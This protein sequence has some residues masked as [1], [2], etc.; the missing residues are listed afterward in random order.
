[1]AAIYGRHLID[2][3][4]ERMGDENHLLGDLSDQTLFNGVWGRG[5]G[6]WGHRDGAPSGIY[7][8]GPE[9][10]YRFGAVQLGMDLYRS[11]GD[12]GARY[13][14]GLYVAYGNG[15]TDVT[16]NVLERTFDAGTDRFNAFSVGGYWTRFGENGWYVDGV[17]QGTWYDVTT[18]SHRTTR[19]GFP[20]QDVDGF[21][22][23]VSLESGYPFD[24]GDGW[25]LEPQAQVVWQTITVDDFNDGAADIRYDNTNSLAG[26][27][28]A[29]VA[30][31]WESEG[32][33]PLEP[34]QLSTVW[35]RVNLWHEFAAEARTEISSAE[36]YVPFS[37]GLDETWI[38]FGI[39]GTRQLLRK[40][41]LYGNVNFST[42]FDGDN[43]A[44]TG[45]VGVRV[46]W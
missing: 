26:R 19:F 43:Y 25:Q 42:T 4:H 46:N 18:Q 21:G 30:R 39:G 32:A 40:T 11:E 1:M 28:G 7:G 15:D 34:A 44:W 41:S 36:G 24:L 5:I 2:T 38:E 33:T 14:A 10:D 9:F 20:D 6:R 22:V 12:D 37:S 13:H 45:K 16:H 17:L 29:R 27:F 8:G 23:A 3:L 35:G 31:T